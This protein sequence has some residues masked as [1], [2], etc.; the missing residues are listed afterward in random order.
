MVEEHI[1][2]LHLQFLHEHT[3]FHPNEINLCLAGRDE[4]TNVEANESTG[5]D[6]A[7]TAENMVDE[8]TRSNNLSRSAESNVYGNI[9]ALNSSNAYF[10]WAKKTELN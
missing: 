7:L 1:Q 9:M 10:G 5:L 8:C 4:L 3:D 2:L 6:V